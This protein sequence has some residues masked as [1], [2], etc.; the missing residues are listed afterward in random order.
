MKSGEVALRVN[1][2]GPQLFFPVTTGSAGIALIVA[3][4]GTGLLKQPIT[5]ATA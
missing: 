1:C 4:A 2:E 5:P 3:I